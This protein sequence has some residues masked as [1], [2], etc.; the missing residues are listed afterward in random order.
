[1]ANYYIDII[2]TTTD[3]HVLQLKHAERNSLVLKWEGGDRKDELAIVPSTLDF[4][5]EVNVHENEDAKFID[6]FTSEEQ[7]FRVSLIAEVG[8][9]VVWSGFL[10]PDSYNE[11]YHNGTFYVNFS[12]ICGLTTL[13][14]RFLS[15]AYYVSEF[16]VLDI[17]KEILS[18][19]NFRL[20]GQLV[21]LLF[22]PAIENV[23]SD[24]YNDLYINGAN[25]VK[26]GEKQSAYDILNDLLTSMLCVCYQADSKWY[27]E[28]VNWRS[29]R[30][31]AYERDFPRPD[32]RVS[33]T[34]KELTAL[35]TPNITVIPAYGKIAVSSND[36]PHELPGDLVTL[37]SVWEQVN[38]KP[39]SFFAKHWR[40]SDID[41]LEVMSY[42]S[43][44]YNLVVRSLDGVVDV[45]NP[46]YRIF[47]PLFV[48][49]GKLY[50]FE[51]KIKIN[52]VDL[53]FLQDVEDEDVDYSVLKNSLRFQLLLNGRVV[54]GNHEVFSAG[55]VLSF[56]VNDNYEGSIVYDVFVA[57]DSMLDIRLFVKNNS[58]PYVGGSVEITALSFEEKT[59]VDDEDVEVLAVAE[60]TVNRDVDLVFSENASALGPVFQLRRLRDRNIVSGTVNLRDFKT[61]PVDINNVYSDAEN[62]YYVISVEHAFL[63]ASFLDNLYPT[64]NAF[65][66]KIS[67]VKN[68]IYNYKNTEEHVLVSDKSVLIQEINVR[69]ISESD[70]VSGD[71]FD[72]LKW[73]D[74]R[75]SEEILSYKKSVANVYA[76]MFSAPSIS[77]EATMNGAVQFNDILNFNYIRSGNYFLTNCAWNIDAGTTDV[78][79]TGVDYGYQSA[80]LASPVLPVVSIVANDDDVYVSP[81]R[82]SVDIFANAYSL[83][84]RISS[85]TWQV[86]SGNARF[87]SGF[88]RATTVFFQDENNVTVRIT[89]VDEF[90]LS[91]FEELTISKVVPLLVGL[92]AVGLNTSVVPHENLDRGY[93]DSLLRTSLKVDAGPLLEETI[94]MVEFSYLIEL[95][96]D[97]VISKEL[98]DEIKMS[99]YLYVYKNN[100]KVACVDLNKLDQRDFNKQVSRVRRGSLKYSYRLGDDLRFEIGSQV[101]LGV[102]QLNYRL[103]IT[104]VSVVSGGQDATLSF[105]DNRNRGYLHRVRFFADETIL[106]NISQSQLDDF[107]EA[108]GELQNGDTVE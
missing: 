15:D 50:A 8:G 4:S 60:T 53:G 27:I 101:T 52:D 44:E 51:F 87:S 78:V 89:V 24:S 33:K 42:E 99:L 22:K 45:S 39:L 1:M 106:T 66:D 74:S 92:E 94:L 12:A 79:M 84:G 54:L 46:Y 10:L 18:L 63:V 38:P 32:P 68:V 47:N 7:R 41:S 81:F 96:R 56:S 36:E 31:V 14:N 107:N 62:Y 73:R 49:G 82:D 71:R 76:R 25:F 67:N 61:I 11:P 102:A 104:D 23:V 75:F 85:Y 93:V 80:G 29:E 40:L 64:A 86:V 57:E 48:R 37:D 17:Y 69:V 13:K 3:T 55:D 100:V 90:G 19:T 43:P 70:L 72:W 103:N 77:I 58:L 26:D 105:V 95:T 34:Y 21:E 91:A 83:S 9:A 30:L 97:V 59:A 108:F 98:F 35:G 16:S 65:T 6:L 20:N 88:A 28:G 2:D 5:L